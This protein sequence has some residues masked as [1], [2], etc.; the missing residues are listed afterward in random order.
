MM[1]RLKLISIISLVSSFGVS[2]V[3]LEK[4]KKKQFKWEKN[5]AHFS[6]DILD[7]FI[8]TADLNNDGYLDYAE[9]AQA[10]RLD[11]P[12]QHSKESL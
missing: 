1:R 3:F 6:P 7:S 12:S 10:I 5:I 4:Q 8:G 9:Y 2:I 11:E